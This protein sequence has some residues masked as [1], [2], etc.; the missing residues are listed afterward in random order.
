MQIPSSN[1]NNLFRSTT[2]IKMEPPTIQAGI[3]Q[4]LS[5]FPYSTPSPTRSQSESQ[6]QSRLIRSLSPSSMPEKSTQITQRDAERRPRPRLVCCSG[7]P[8]QFA[9]SLSYEGSERN[10]WKNLRTQRKR[11]RVES[12]VYK[13]LQGQHNC[14]LSSFGSGAQHREYVFFC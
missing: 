11:G 12:T 7:Y 6:S 5:L 8:K 1:N 14:Q 9:P 13:V 3:K 2:A 10:T 4:S